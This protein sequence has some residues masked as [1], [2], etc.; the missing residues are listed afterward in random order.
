MPITGNLAVLTLSIIVIS[1]LAGI[2]YQAASETLDRRRYPPQGELVD[3]GGFRLH[4]NCM[5]QGK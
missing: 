5:G 1:L 2:L 3:I 4:L